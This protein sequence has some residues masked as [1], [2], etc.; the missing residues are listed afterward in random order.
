MNPRYLK[1]LS[2]AGHREREHAYMAAITLS[3]RCD[4]LFGMYV[5]L[6]GGKDI[7]GFLRLVANAWEEKPSKFDLTQTGENI[8][9]AWWEAYGIAGR[10]IHGFE[11]LAR[12]TLL[13]IK[14][15]YVVLSRRKPPED[16][17]KL[18]HWIADLEARKAIPSDWTFRTTLDRLKLP[19]LKKGNRSR[20]TT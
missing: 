17:A 2:L 11:M 3:N 5:R 4:E 10:G 12:P 6:F 13:E 14:V 15:Q 20:V 18:R 8:V 16:R 1:L 7:P 19:Y 9:K